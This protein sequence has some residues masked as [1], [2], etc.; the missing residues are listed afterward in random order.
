MSADNR[1]TDLETAEPIVQIRD[2]RKSYRLG[3]RAVEV[4]K[5]VSFDVARGEM[6]AIKGASGTGKSTL[7]HLMGGLDRPDSGGIECAGENLAKMSGGRLNRYRNSTIGLVFQAYHLLPELDALE[8]V[9]LPARLARRGYSEVRDEAKSLLERVGL[10]HRV[11]H[12]PYELS[13]GEQQRV[14]LARSLINRPQL[15]LADEPTGNLDS[16]TGAEIL[17]LMEGLR[18]EK[19]LTLV[20]ATH[21]DHLAERAP[22]SIHLHDGQIVD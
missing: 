13:G 15:L 4:L 6:V 16:K 12:R 11:D 1:Q 9:C 19:A 3:K 2:L 22:R 10:G 5:G 14:A 17:E 7:L 21:D 18:E 20:I 8:N